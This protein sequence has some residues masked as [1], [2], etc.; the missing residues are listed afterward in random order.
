MR[1]GL[2]GTRLISTLAL[3]VRT[4]LIPTLTGLIATLLTG[5]VA[6]LLTGLIAIA[7]LLIAWVFR[8]TVHIRLRRR[9]I[10]FFIAVFMICIVCRETEGLNADAGSF[11]FF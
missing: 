2:I 7:S 5:L 10:H 9:V 11:R 8:M 4:L 6:T 3:L 1:T